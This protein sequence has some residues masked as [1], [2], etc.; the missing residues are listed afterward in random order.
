M[1]INGWTLL[2]HD[3]VIGQIETL[4]AADRRAR[5]AAPQRYRA[6]ANVKLLAALAKLILEDIP[7]DPGRPEYRQGNTLGSGHRHWFRAKFFG[8][9]RLFFR[10][11]S[12]ARLIVFAWVNDEHSLR[13]HGGR[14]DPYALFRR[15]LESGDPPDDW[16]T[17]VQR[18][19][20][21]PKDALGTVVT[22]VEKSR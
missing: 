13:Q 20:R 14:S 2:F 1:L 5:K 6:N 17:L 21:L 7:G 3:A 12:R 22:A 10:Y 4:V 11:D 9:F 18:S 15:M 8:R 16:Q 19:R